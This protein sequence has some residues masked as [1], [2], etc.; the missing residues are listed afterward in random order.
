MN[1][2]IVLND[3]E[4]L[5]P[6]KQEEVFD[7]VA[8]LKTRTRRQKKQVGEAGKIASSESGGFFGMWADRESMKDSDR[9]V[10]QLRTKEW[11]R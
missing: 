11:G 8:F 10:R 9:W 3:I 2:E 4:S 5:P 1:I 7:F 6:D